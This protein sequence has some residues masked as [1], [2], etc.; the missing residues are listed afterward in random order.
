MSK[1]KIYRKIENIEL[2][3]HEPK[4]FLRR[5]VKPTIKDEP[6]AG[7]HRFWDSVTAA[8]CCKYNSHLRKVIPAVVQGEG[9][10]LGY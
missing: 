5:V 4:T 1:T 2:L 9:R 8:K 7:I 6:V 3:W 10:A